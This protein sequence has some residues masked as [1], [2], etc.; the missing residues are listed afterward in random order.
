[1]T[2]NPAP[3]TASEPDADATADDSAEA[4]SATSERSPGRG[5]VTLLRQPNLRRLW[6]AQGWAIA[7]EALA[8]IAMPLLV[9]S[10]SGS[11]GQVS[12]I[13]LLLILPRV[14]LAPIAGLL[15][16]RLNRRR[17]IILADA[18]RLVLVSLVPLAGEAWQIA[19]LAVGIGLGNA[20]ARPA[21]L[22]L[23]PAV[24]GPKLLV[25][26]LSLIQV[27]RGIIRVVVP[28]AGAGVIAA[29]GPGPTFW[30]QS[31]CFVGSL[32]ALRKLHAPDADR[33]PISGWGQVQAMWLA[34]KREMWAGLGAVRS[35]PIVRGITASEI[36]WQ[37]VS[38]ALVVTAVVYTQET[39][40]LAARAD[41]AFALMTTSFS[42]GAVIGAVLAHRIE[43]RLG[44]PMLM[45][46]GYVGP[47]FLV[48]AAFSPPM[49][50]IYAAWFC[51]G[52]A[53]AW[54]V[55][56]FQAYLAEAVEDQL[57]GRVYATFD[58]LTWLGTAGAF[59]LLGVV[60]PMLG[61]PA[62][63]GWVGL[64]VGFGAPL[65]LWATGA[66]RSIRQRVPA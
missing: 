43:L 62:T 39:L 40:D 51:L 57:R 29:V 66:L 35:I 63:F 30:L 32:L 24:V 26:A 18:E 65:L 5:V 47:I 14:I 4:V 12:F 61:A 34:A 21:E 37:L 64:I 33:P 52:L 54:A 50:V 38:A 25:P 6:T 31:A 3:A 58:A 27:T 46:I 42:A 9:Y 15:A 48:A 36:L 11:A 1:M 28:A 49:P 23:V 59:S 8:Q 19:V 60:T 17:L 41:A 10:L 55:I 56:S 7:G 20:I 13:A 22:A 16:D 44:R 53:D 2:T 45:A